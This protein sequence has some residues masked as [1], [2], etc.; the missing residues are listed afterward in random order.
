V[1]KNTGEM[2]GVDYYEL[3][4]SADGGLTW[5]PPAAG[6]GVDF[7]RRWL[8]VGTLTTGDEAFPYQL[9][10]GR[11]VYESRE[12]F[13]ANNY[14]GDWWPAGDRFWL[15]NDNLLVP[16]RLEQVRRRDV[17]LPLRRL[18]LGGGGDLLNRQVI[19]SA[20]ASSTTISSSPSTTR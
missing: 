8:D 9:A 2:L 15:I 11:Y 17:P 3:E 18:G 13:E 20:G 14:V 6:G 12:H 4:Y 16:P 5:N 1:L 10:C 19:R 7:K